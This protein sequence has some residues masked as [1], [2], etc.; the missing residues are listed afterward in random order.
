MLLATKYQSNPHVLRDTNQKLTI[1]RKAFANNISQT[2]NGVA[3]LS[4]F[5]ASVSAYITS[6]NL[7]LDDMCLASVNKNVTINLLNDNGW[8]HPCCTTRDF[9][10]SNLFNT[11]KGIPTTK[12][13]SVVQNLGS[14]SISSPKPITQLISQSSTLAQNV[15]PS[16][17]HLGHIV[18]SDAQKTTNSMSGKKTMGANAFT[19]CS[20]LASVR[21]SSDNAWNAFYSDG[22]FK[23]CS[24]LTTINTVTNSNSSMSLNAGV[25]PPIGNISVVAGITTVN[26]TNTQ[27]ASTIF[28]PGQMLYTSSDTREGAKYIGTI[29][30]IQNNLQIILVLPSMLTYSGGFRL[31]TEAMISAN[32]TSIGKETLRGTNVRVISVEAHLNPSAAPSNSRILTIGTNFCTD[33]ANLA[34]VHFSVKQNNALMR[35]GTESDVIPLTT[36]LSVLTSDDW[37]PATSQTQLSNLFLVPTSRFTT[38]AKYTG[39]FRLNQNV[40]DSYGNP[41]TQ[42]IVTITGFAFSD[43]PLYL[44]NLVIPEYLTHSDGK[45]YQVYD[46]NYPFIDQVETIVG[47][48]NRVYGAFSKSNPAF[49][50]IGAL[51]GTLTFPKTL[52][53]IGGNS[54]ANQGGLSGNLTFTCP[55]LYSIGYRAF[56]SSYT[57][58]GTKVLT[59]L[60]SP[61]VEFNYGV[62]SFNGTNFG[63]TNMQKMNDLQ[64]VQYSF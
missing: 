12:N 25:T 22:C 11:G 58:F 17:D 5:I 47:Q 43:Q 4:R 14:S 10:T 34:T 29:K 26:G 59:V 64:M 56:I 2:V 39:I 23:S 57:T 36:K 61:M 48:Q 55:L 24:S 33:C 35:I 18:F 41:T 60:T 53:A 13:I 45:L 6:E 32:A 46:I 52:R 3:E 42:N 19:G 63:I 31:T 49:A 21:M 9:N 38:T 1:M 62:E 20:R 30:S 50:S 8:D 15:L 7:A 40:T 16:R 37:S 54:F 27:F 44:R 28:I 51:T